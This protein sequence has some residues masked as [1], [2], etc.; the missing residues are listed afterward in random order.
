VSMENVY[1]QNFT[2][3]LAWVGLVLL[4]IAIVYNEETSLLLKDGR[5]GSRLSASRVVR[6]ISRLQPLRGILIERLSTRPPLMLRMYLQHR[7]KPGRDRHGMGS[8]R[9]YSNYDKNAG[10][11]F[12]FVFFFPFH[13][14]QYISLSR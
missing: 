10:R 8:A 14:L 6:P 2:R 4:T 12:S 5:I 9:L 13:I 3:R 11:L 7:H 1:T